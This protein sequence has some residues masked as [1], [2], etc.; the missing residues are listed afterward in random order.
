MQRRPTDALAPAAE[1][2]VRPPIARPPEASAQQPRTRLRK[3]ILTARTMKQN[4]SCIV[5][6]VSC[7]INSKP[8]STW[9]LF[10]RSSSFAPALR[11]L[12]RRTKLTTRITLPLFPRITLHMVSKP[13]RHGPMSSHPP[14]Q[15][16]TSRKCLALSSRLRTTL[17]SRQNL[18]SRLSWHMLQHHMHALPSRPNLRPRSP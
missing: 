9:C 13:V 10:S 14:H 5:S 7:P 15:A 4:Q 12:H 8:T 18:L 11:H 3:S 1:P 17:S 2:S 16:T 6:C